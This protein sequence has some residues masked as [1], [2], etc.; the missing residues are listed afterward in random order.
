[1]STL[2]Q[3]AFAEAFGAAVSKAKASFPE[4]ADHTILVSVKFFFPHPKKHFFQNPHIKQL[5]LHAHAPTYVTKTPDIDNCIKLI[6]D[7][8]QKI[9]CKN[10]YQVANLKA[11]KMYDHS[12]TIWDETKAK[13]GCTLIKVVVLNEHVVEETCDCESCKHKKKTKTSAL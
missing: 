1:M 9:I 13:T 10:D 6:P 7:S 2:N 8:L 4:S 5:C 3:T 12:H 11:T